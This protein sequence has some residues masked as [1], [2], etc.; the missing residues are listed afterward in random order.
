M[1]AEDPAAK[2]PPKGLDHRQGCS[3]FGLAAWRYGG[4]VQRNVP[5]YPEIKKREPWLE[6]SNR[7]AYPQTS[8][9][10]LTTGKTS[11]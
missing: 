10:R 2:S 4:F 6:Y 5:N 3:A 7:L 9:T 11:P 8:L 1:T